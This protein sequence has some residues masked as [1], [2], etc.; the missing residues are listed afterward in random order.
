MS[1]MVQ[2]RTDLI[3]FFFNENKT[4]TKKE[5]LNREFAVLSFSPTE[6][7]IDTL[8][9]PFD[10]ICV[11]LSTYIMVDTNEVFV[12]GIIVDIDRQNFQTIIHVQNKDSI[13]SVV[14]KGAALEEYDDYFIVGEPIIV[15]CKVY[16]ERMYL[17]FLIQLNDIDKF[18]KE[19]DYING[20]SKETIDTIMSDDQKRSRTHY[21][22]LIECAMVK[23]NKGKDMFRGTLYDGEQIRSF[24]IVKTS[25]NP[26]LPKH[27]LAGD[28]VRFNKPTQDFFLSNMEVV[29]L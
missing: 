18:Q 14:A 4:Y 20:V 25:Y 8:D 6:E 13:V 10:D 21:G 7:Y 24:G 15:K 26:V 22:L 12:K 28:F 11:D 5:I 1:D 27:A 19:C 23:T 29:E 2:K 16:N 9:S 17:S 3:N